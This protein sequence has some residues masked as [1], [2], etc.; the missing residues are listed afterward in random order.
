MF[1]V[2]FCVDV[3]NKIVYKTRVIYDMT[4]FALCFGM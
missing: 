3:V 2:S 4:G 1:I